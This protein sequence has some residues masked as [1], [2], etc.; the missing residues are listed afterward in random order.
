MDENRENM[1]TDQPTTG[2]EESTSKS[3]LTNDLHAA[4]LTKKSSPEKMDANQENVNVDR[5]NISKEESSKNELNHSSTESLTEKL[6]SNKTDESREI[7][8]VDQQNCDGEELCTAP[9]LTEGS[10]SPDLNT[11]TEINIEQSLAVEEL[12]PSQASNTNVILCNEDS[13]QTKIDTEKVPLTSDQTMVIVN[14]E[15]SNDNDASLDINDEPSNKLCVTEAMD[16]L[17]NIITH[18]CEESEN[19]DDTVKPSSAT[20]IKDEIVITNEIIII[21]NDAVNKDGINK[22]TS[23]SENADLNNETD[24]N[25]TTEDLYYIG[26]YVTQ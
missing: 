17:D 20:V 6:D 22:Q 2:E 15:K 3:E 16:V 26:N 21:D 23:P 18:V 13:D 5:Q 1:N 10:D 7:M 25:Q 24:E 11:L 9:T 14:N 4:F 8:N 19:C 12:E